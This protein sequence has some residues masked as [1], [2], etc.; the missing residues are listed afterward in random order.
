MKTIKD[1][2]KEL[3]IAPSTVSRV[4]NKSG[5]YSKEVEE[6]VLK[7]VEETGFIYN[8]SAKMLRSKKSNTIGLIIPDISNDFYSRIALIVDTFFSKRGYSIFICNTASD[9]KRELVAFKQ[10]VANQ[11]NGIIFLGYGSLLDDQ[12]I[13]YDVPIVALDRPY[14]GKLPATQIY[15]NDLDL[16][17]QAGKLLIAKGCKKIRIL[18][19]EFNVLDDPSV[20]LDPSYQKNGRVT[21]ITEEILN[22]FP[23]TDPLKLVEKIPYY[24]GM[25]IEESEKKVASLIAEEKDIDGL[26]CMSDNVAYGAVKALKKAGKKIPDEVKVIGFDNNIY[27]SISSPSITSVDRNVDTMASTACLKLLEKIE[28]G[29]K[30]SEETIVIEGMLVER[31]TT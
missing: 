24:R 21:G 11:V 13:K 25:A 2:A 30:M 20:L 9:L 26:F 31:E 5:Y 1:I 19:R 12:F 22:R 27:S 4:L 8:Q 3:G 23:E 17:R 29:D 6:K 7:Y 15:S 16:S 14:Y 28:S 18:V 10:L